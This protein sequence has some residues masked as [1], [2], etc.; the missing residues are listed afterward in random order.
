ML[1]LKQFNLK[2]IHF[3]I[4]RLMGIK[5][6]RLFKISYIW[7]HLSVLLY[8]F[9]NHYL[10]LYII[11]Q[12]KLHIG[13]VSSKKQDI[14]GIEINEQNSTL[15][16]DL[17]SKVK[18]FLESN[19]SMDKIKFILSLDSDTELAI[20]LD[21]LYNGLLVYKYDAG[22]KNTVYS[23]YA[24]SHLFRLLE[25]NREICTKSDSLI[26]SILSPE[27]TYLFSDIVINLPTL[28]VYGFLDVSSILKSTDLY[29]EFDLYR[30]ISTNPNS[31]EFDTKFC[32]YL[33]PSILTGSDLQR[34]LT[35]DKIMDLRSK[36]FNKIKEWCRV[37]HISENHDLFNNLANVFVLTLFESFKREYIELGNEFFEVAIK[38][39]NSSADYKLSTYD[40]STRLCIRTL[41]LFKSLTTKLLGFH[42][43]VVLSQHQEL[44]PAICKSI[45]CK[46]NSAV[47]FQE[48]KLLCFY[49]LESNPNITKDFR[50][51]Y[52]KLQELEQNYKKYSDFTHI[53]TEFFWYK[54]VLIYLIGMILFYPLATFVFNITNLRNTIIRYIY[55]IIPYEEWVSCLFVSNLLVMGYLLG[56]FN[57]AVY[58][59]NYS[60][61]SN[62]YVFKPF[63]QLFL[64]SIKSINIGIIYYV[65]L[66]IS[67]GFW[68]YYR[69]PEYNLVSLYSIG[70]I[71]LG[72]MFIVFSG[73]LN[74]VNL[75]KYLKLEYNIHNMLYS[76][77]NPN[78]KFLNANPI[79][80]IHSLIYFTNLNTDN[81]LKINDL[82]LNPILN[83]IYYRLVFGLFICTL[84][85]PFILDL[86]SIPILGV[87]EYTIAT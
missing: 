2:P 53:L 65:L 26:K 60:I 77:I 20:K 37:N 21:S 48:L 68:M 3:R 28:D 22:K 72:F 52:N 56:L 9:L 14:Y 29:S 6:L 33:L 8:L 64:E 47:T 44:V 27:I 24:I 82:A 81:L 12:Y 58:W 69:I 74:F 85:A 13:N 76:Y 32:Q 17:D 57:L 63:Y 10:N 19:E 34:Q 66:N 80:K 45:N 23:E 49:S 35:I 31:K 70:L 5:L 87:S 73:I 84:L 51:R 15:L 38:N 78:S 61:F 41:Q 18:L 1:Y 75:R 16:Q 36:I 42:K 86:K 7:I 59:S 55:Y 25:A 83:L 4:T 11:K 79:Q 67:F 54:L 50:Y 71:T 62:A 39:L 30:F 40:N 43:F 46:I